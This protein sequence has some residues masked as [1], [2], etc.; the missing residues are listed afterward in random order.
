MSMY[1]NYYLGYLD[2]NKKVVPLGPFNNEGKLKELFFYSHNYDFRVHDDFYRLNWEDLSDEFKE[3][4][5]R[6]FSYSDGESLKDIWHPNSWG[7]LPLKEFIN[8]VTSIQRFIKTGYWEI[9]EIEAF[10]SLPEEDRNDYLYSGNLP[11]PMHPDVYAAK[12]T[13]D[14]EAAKNYMFYAV[15]DIYV[16]D[17]YRYLAYVMTSRLT[18]DYEHRDRE[19]VIFYYYA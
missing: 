16:D 1:Y 9:G 19:Y 4:L 2:E 3:I 6:E 15:C 14:P 7:Y 18:D 13:A 10:L 12:V 17:Y 11:Y 8:G 5:G